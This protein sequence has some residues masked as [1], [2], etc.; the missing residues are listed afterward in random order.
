MPSVREKQV[1]TW[2][3]VKGSSGNVYLV[4]RI[5]TARNATVNEAPAGSEPAPLYRVASSH[6]YVTHSASDDTFRILGSD[7][8]LRRI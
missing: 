8:V 7:E 1:V 4:E 6:M 5:E 3:K 2:F